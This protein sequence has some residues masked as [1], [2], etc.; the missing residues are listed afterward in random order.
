MLFRSKELLH[1]FLFEFN[2]EGTRA[3]VRAL[4]KTYMDGIQARK[5]VEKYE[6]VCDETNNT[7]DRID[8]HELVVDLL[9]CPKSSIEYIPFTIGITNNSISFDLAKQAL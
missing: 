1:S 4:I 2:D 9:V 7:P 8:N 6:I 3:I 5:G